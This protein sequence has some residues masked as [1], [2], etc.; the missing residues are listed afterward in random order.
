VKAIV[1]SQDDD[2]DAVADAL[3][4]G[5]LEG[6]DVEAGRIEIPI[7]EGLEGKLQMIVVVIAD[8]AAQ[9]VAT[10][11][12]EYYGGGN[13]WCPWVWVSIRITSLAPLGSEPVTYEVGGIAEHH[14]SWYLQNGLSIP[15]KFIHTMIQVTGVPL[16]VM[17]LRLM[18]LTPKV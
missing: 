15:V 2:A 4:S 10:A 6:I 9:S 13:P 12:F 8:G 3:A 17:I 5:E 16:A 11:N 7:A 1:M 14:T 18:L